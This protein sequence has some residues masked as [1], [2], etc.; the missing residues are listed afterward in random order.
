MHS[1][2]FY[3]SKVIMRKTYCVNVTCTKIK[4]KNTEAL[5]P[6]LGPVLDLEQALVDVLFMPTQTPPSIFPCSRL[7]FS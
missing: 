5:S 4:S 1:N 2:K 3:H 6:L 7:Y